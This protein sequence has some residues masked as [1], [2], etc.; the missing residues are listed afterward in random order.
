MTHCWFDRAHQ[1]LDSASESHGIRESFSLMTDGEVAK[2]C[3]SSIPWD[4][5]LAF[6]KALA[7]NSV[8]RLPWAALVPCQ[9][10]MFEEESAQRLPSRLSL[11]GSSRSEDG[12]RLLPRNVL[13]YLAHQ[14]LALVLFANGGGYHGAV[15][16]KR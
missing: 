12:N 4:D 1:I 9:L 15:R 16:G 3:F 14:R 8:L 5:S 13:V 7:E 11:V 2:F 6:G 10:M